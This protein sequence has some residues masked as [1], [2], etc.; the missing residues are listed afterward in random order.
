MLNQLRMYVEYYLSFCL[1]ICIK[2]NL[3]PINNEVKIMVAMRVIAVF[4]FTKIQFCGGIQEM[5]IKMKQQL[6]LLK[7]LLKKL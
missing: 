5:H 6:L 4:A 3:I 1:N 7:Y 2:I